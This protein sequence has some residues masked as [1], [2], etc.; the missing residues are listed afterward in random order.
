MRQT[1]TAA[2]EYRIDEQLNLSAEARAELLPRVDVL[3]RRLSEPRPARWVGAAVEVLTTWPAVP[4]T[5]VAA[6]QA[7][8]SSTF[9]TAVVYDQCP[10]EPQATGPVAADPKGVQL[11]VKRAR[12][13]GADAIVLHLS[14]A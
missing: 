8:G 7:P 13:F 12:V 6:M 4:F 10:T 2:P 9:A 3:S 11:L 5:R 1:A 14:G